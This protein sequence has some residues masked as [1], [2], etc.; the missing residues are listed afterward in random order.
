MVIKRCCTR[1]TQDISMCTVTLGLITI[2]L[3]G[4][5]LG[6]QGS[7]S[8]VPQ[9]PG[10]RPLLTLPIILLVFHKELCFLSTHLRLGQAWDWPDSQQLD[11]ER[12]EKVAQEES[13]FLLYLKDLFLFQK[14]YVVYRSRRIRFCRF[15]KCFGNLTCFPLGMIVV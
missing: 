13:F 12:F 2:I 5:E 15:K 10:P 9:G 4:E 7:K 8:Q 3:C 14:N 1:G 11:A 6:S